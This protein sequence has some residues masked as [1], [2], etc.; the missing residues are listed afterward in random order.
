MTELAAG[1]ILFL[2]AHSI[3]IIAPAWRDQVAAKIGLR[4]WQ[5]IYAVIA[6]VGLILI[7]RGYSD[8][9]NQTAILYQFP[10]WMQAISSTLMLPVFPLLLAA[11][12]PGMI[13][14]AAKHPMLV[15]VKLWALAHL[16]ANGSVADVVLFG[17]VLAWAVADRI[18][19]K[20][21]TPRPTPA[22]PPG[23][24]NDLIAIIGGMLIYAV[25]LNGGHR[26]LTGM[27][28]ILR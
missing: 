18:S 25:I 12:L 28:L 9:R 17:S 14:T 4:S 5:G 8:V 26:W 1:L 13:K 22:A 3:S 2:G 7:V 27:P 21:R 19:L 15:A 11:Y 16:L 6:L 20:R 24:W 10:R 23:R